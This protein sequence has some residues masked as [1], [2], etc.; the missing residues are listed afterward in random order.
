MD[1]L[2][3]FVQCTC[4]YN[5]HCT[6][7]GSASSN[8][9][10]N[11]EIVDPNKEDGAIEKRYYGCFGPYKVVRVMIERYYGRSVPHKEDGEIVDRSYRR[12]NLHKVDRYYNSPEESEVPNRRSDPKHCV[13]FMLKYMK[14]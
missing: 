3:T 11:L 12:F 4:P 5:V 7:G 2:S 6:G 13:T 10:L 1:I 14:Y 9:S 8:F